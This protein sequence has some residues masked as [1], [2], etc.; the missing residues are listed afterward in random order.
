MLWT[1]D[2]AIVARAAR[3]T[4]ALA[5]RQRQCQSGRADGRRI[6]RLSAKSTGVPAPDPEEVPCASDV[7]N[8][9]I[10]TCSM[11]ARVPLG[12]PAGS[13]LHLNERSG[14]CWCVLSVVR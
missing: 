8:S 7:C 14:G 6:A 4:G 10:L 1:D 13:G 9:A 11:S 3:D 5:T 2:Y 12:E